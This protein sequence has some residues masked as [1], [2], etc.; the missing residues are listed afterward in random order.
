[1]LNSPTLFGHEAAGR[2]GGVWVWQELVVGKSAI[3]ELRTTLPP[4]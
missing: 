4:A 1:M 2:I 3:S